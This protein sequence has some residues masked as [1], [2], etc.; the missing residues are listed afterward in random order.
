MRITLTGK[1]S[2]IQIDKKRG[3]VFYRRLCH[4]RKT[5]LRFATHRI[6]QYPSFGAAVEKARQ[7]IRAVEGLADAEIK[8]ERES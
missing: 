4:N 5:F 7:Y 1:K 8:E 6:D 2:Q 3:L